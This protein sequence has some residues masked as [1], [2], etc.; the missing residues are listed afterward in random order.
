VIVDSE[1][2]SRVLDERRRRRIG[3]RLAIAAVIVIA[4][5]VAA[6]AAF[7]TMLNSA[8]SDIGSRRHLAP[9]PIASD[10][11]PYVRVMHAAANE[12]QRNQPIPAFDLR[13]SGSRQQRTTLTWPKSRGRFGQALGAFE[14]ALVV[15]KPHFPLRV[16]HYL[17]A[18]LTD[19][20]T[21]RALLGAQSDQA[22][23]DRYMDLFADG[24][25]AFGY[26]G[27]LIGRQCGGQLGADEDSMPTL[28][29]AV[30]TAPTRSRPAP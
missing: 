11:C 2:H 10:A 13:T 5:G 21:G 4:L 22:L 28:H 16:K 15:S 29:F 19:V 8:F 7:S 9:I 17:G 3:R 26:A 27:D 24:R 20:R 14:S 30:I 6:V 12:V 25:E 23:A 1:P 18:T